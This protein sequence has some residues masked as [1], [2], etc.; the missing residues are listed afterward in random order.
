MTGVQTCALPIYK[1]IWKI[2]LYTGGTVQSNGV[3][4]RILFSLIAA[5][6]FFFNKKLFR[7]NFPQWYGI[8][9]MSSFIII[10]L[11]ITAFKFSTISD[12]FGLYFSFIQ[13]LVF[14]NFII[15]IKNINI[16]IM[17]VSI[18]SLVY[19]FS[20]YIWLTYSYWANHAWIPYSNIL[21]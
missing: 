11:A 5:L 18:I 17:Y 4:I 14:S 16:K 12:R 3:Y 2:E 1:I 6:L 9:N 13:V 15:F 19:M 8:I 21:L 10:I 20:L 7:K